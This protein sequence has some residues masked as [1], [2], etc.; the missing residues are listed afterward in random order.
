M[1]TN[2]GTAAAAKVLLD[3]A[4]GA[5]LFGLSVVASSFLNTHRRLSM[6][7]T[8]STL[9][10]ETLR[11]LFYAT[12]KA[13]SRH[14][15]SVVVSSTELFHARKAFFDEHAGLT[16]TNPRV[17]HVA[18]TK[19]KGSTVEYIAAGLRRASTV[20]VFTSPHLHTARERVKVGT[21][22][23]SQADVVRYGDEALSLMAAVPWAVFFDKLLLLAMRYFDAQDGLEYLVMEA[24]IGGRF[25]ST[26]FIAT[27]AAAVITSI[28]L[29]HQ[30]LLGD[31]VAQIA[32]QKAGIIKAGGHVFTSAAQDPVALDVFRARC[33]EV[34]A[35]LHVVPADRDRVASLVPLRGDH[36]S[37][38][39]QNACLARA[40]L[41]HLNVDPAGM[42]DFY[43]PC[44]METFAVP[45][46]SRHVTVV[47]DGCH[48]EDS[49][50]LFLAG[51]RH[52]YPPRTH[53]L[54]VLFGAGMEKYLGEMLRHLFALAD[55]VVFVQSRHFKALS[56]ADL[57][58]AAVGVEGVGTA[59]L[60]V[61]LLN[62]VDDDTGGSS[63]SSSS[64]SGH[65][66]RNSG[67]SS[68]ASPCGGCGPA[69]HGPRGRKAE[70]T[71]PDRLQWA[72]AHADI[73][74][75]VRGR[76]VVV[77]VCGSLF[78]ASDARE[79]LYSRCPALFADDDWVRECD[80]PI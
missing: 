26:N 52:E 40:V 22:L 77:A 11:K 33:A 14:T 66:N 38:Q 1:P 37:V 79:A 2:V 25:D 71:V 41:E 75:D 9:Y 39:V 31:T 15:D 76:A 51:L 8:T 35:T 19:G 54:L 55:G 42:R 57:V 30:A 69:T 61:K 48:N 53:A 46:P 23:I 70:G 16:R 20:G 21:Q 36:Y 24:G 32:W 28:S 17:I 65:S 43:W 29:D 3:A 68:S 63:S 45:V 78:A 10:V 12:F 59:A 62:Y 64:S 4:A 74:T 60:Q 6:Q 18:G 34:D 56:E 5:L 47:L 13:P 80:P 67:S 50:R 7:T 44:R 72:V 27:P 58:A 73:E 49:V